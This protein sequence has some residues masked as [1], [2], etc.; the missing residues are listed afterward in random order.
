MLEGK[1]IIV[2]ITGSIAAYKSAELIR[3][4]IKSEAEVKVIMS[5]SAIEFVTPLTFSTLSKNPVSSDF[6][7]NK[8]T[9]EWTNH[10][11]LGLWADLF[12]IAPCTA[13]SLAKMVSGTS[14]NF[15]LAVF[16][17]TKCPVMIAPAMD[18]DMYV[19][20]A[21]QDNL[22][23]F[24][25]RG[26][27]IVDSEKGELASGLHGKGRMAEPA[28]ILTAV[29]K[30]FHPSL[31]LEGMQALVSAGPTHE[32]IDPVRFI[33]NHSS[34][35]MG[36]ALAEELARKGARV[37]LVTGPTTEHLNISSIERIDVVSADDMFTEISSR[38][39]KMDIAIMAA[40]VADFRPSTVAGQKIKKST[41]SMII[42]LEPTKDILR[43]LGQQKK[44][45]QTLIGFALETEN[46]QENAQNKL[47]RK[48]LDFIVINSLKDPGAGF[49]H[50]TNKISILDRNNKLISFE[51]KSKTE[52]ATDI[53]SVLIDFIQT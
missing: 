37:T 16:L 18:R 31:P 39:E 45:K 42:D 2:G 20:K 38:F 11:E 5:P 25:S 28:N 32:A 41:A 53:V 46:E 52:A 30:F 4:L 6:T 35:K 34:G 24:E 27:I 36:F 3:L 12:L 17:S 10:V 33:G 48:N 29:E 8:D 51:L 21:T 7:E 49:G 26:G 19:H 43:S 22:S 44:A 14:D 40:A 13:N 50:D 47:I 1:K 23:V 9:G 15:L